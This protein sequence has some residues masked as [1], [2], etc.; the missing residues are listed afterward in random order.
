MTALR[1]VLKNGS[2]DH[3]E[4]HYARIEDRENEF[5]AIRGALKT[6]RRDR[7]AVRMIHSVER[8]KLMPLIERPG[9]QHW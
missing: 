3:C 6:C 7:F 2:S 9:I 5:H 4:L 8:Y 1:A